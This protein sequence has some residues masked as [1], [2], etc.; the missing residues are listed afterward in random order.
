MKNDIKGKKPHISIVVPVFNEE[1]S[2]KDLHS[3]IVNVCKKFCKSSEIIFVN[4]GSFDNTLEILKTL[5]PIKIINLRRNFGQTSAIDA[6]IKYA[7][8]DYI[9]TL[10][11]DG[12]NDPEDISYL[13]KELE[14]KNLDVVSGW[15]VERNDS[16]DKKVFSKVANFIREVLLKDGIHDSGCT[17]K[18]YRR[19]CFE[20]VDL[21]GEVHRFIPA[22]L[23]IKGFKVGELPVRHNPR[24]SGETKYDWKRSFKG[25]TDIISI[26][27]WQKYSNRPLHLFGGAG[28]IMILIS[29]I[30]GLY[31]FY[32]KFVLGTDLSGTVSPLITVFVFFVGFQFFISG[33]LAD[34]SVKSYFS[35][36]KD[37][38]YVIKEILVKD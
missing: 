6:G 23:K 27:F 20:N 7:T 36:T 21:Y 17:L 13:I 32:E 18:V 3:K 10:D 38:P 5:S 30:M 22:I 28:I 29:S 14:S 2:V 24:I 34:I 33:L 37:K 16:L 19:E 25:I 11:G 9:V 35:S 1:N 12:Q 31:L 8:G 26:W 4:D 15:R